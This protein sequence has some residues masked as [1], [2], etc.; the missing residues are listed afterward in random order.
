M[1]LRS[2]LPEEYGDFTYRFVGRAVVCNGEVVVPGTS[3]TRRVAIVFRGS[4][5]RTPPIVMSDGPRR[6]RHRYRWARPTSL[7]LWHP[8]D[9]DTQRWMPRNGFGVLVD[10]VRSHLLKE[11]WWRMF[12]RWDAP[13]V[14]DAP[15]GDECRRLGPGR[16][17]TRRLKRDQFDC[18]CGQQSYL[19]CHGAVDE[20]EELRVLGLAAAR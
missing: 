20:Q 1:G 5:S 4:P 6:S 13:E 16:R 2:S 11:L 14:H 15:L 19:T 17:T 18:W 7:C 3:K 10:I 8:S 12:D 9:P